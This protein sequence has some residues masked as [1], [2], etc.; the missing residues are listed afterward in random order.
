MIRSIG[1]VLLLSFGS[2]LVA[3]GR[4]YSDSFESPPIVRQFP[5]VGGAYQLPAGPTTNQLVWLLSELAVGETTTEAE[6]NTHF[7]PA[8]LAQVDAATTVTFINSIRTS[9]PNAAVVDVIAVTPVR[10]TVLIDSPSA[11]GA[12]F[13]FMSLGARYAGTQRI[14]LF[15]VSAFNNVM[16][17]A[18]QALSLVQ[19]ADKFAT[20]SSAPGLFVGRVRPGGVCEPIIERQSTTLRA[21]ASIFKTWVLGGVARA[22]ANNTITATTSIPMVASELAPGGIINAEPVGTP[23][24]AGELAILMMGISDNTAT[25]LLHQQVG[26]PVIN[27]VVSDYAM[28]QPTVLTPLLGISEQFH[29][30]RSFDLATANSYVNGTEP[31]QQ[32]FLDTQIVPLGPCCSGPTFH[33]ELLTAG[34]WRATAADVCRAFAGL[35][36]TAQGSDA[37]DLVD[38][39]MGAQVAQPGVRNLWDRAWY[40][41]GS[42]A[43]GNPVQ[44]RVLTHAWLLEDTGR[45]PYVVVAMSN[46]PSTD[47][48]APGINQF[49]VQSVLGRILQLT[50]QLP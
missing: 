47:P 1:L 17:P 38:R 15:G 24:P 10:L 23:F 43:A 49:D 2:P 4:L 19:A 50:D 45:D 21:T 28:S 34:T 6:V 46:S 11:P 16:F 40:K 7:D 35:R 22:V 18:D 12:P 30:F 9:Y 48:G 3:Q 14:V 13:G 39:A 8:W 33:T 5:L 36:R 31:F 41:G 37:F 20:L 44:F 25:D 27:Q 32:N 26:R 29:V 42:L